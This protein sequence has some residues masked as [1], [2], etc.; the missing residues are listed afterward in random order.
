MWVL[1]TFPLYWGQSDFCLMTTHVWCLLSTSSKLHSIAPE[2]ASE[3][4]QGSSVSSQ[5]SWR[6]WDEVLSQKKVVVCYRT[7][8]RTGYQSTHTPTPVMFFFPP[9]N[10]INMTTVII[11]LWF[12]CNQS[13]K[14]PNKS[15]FYT[16]YHILLSGSLWI[17]WGDVVMLTLWWLS[18]ILQVSSPSLSH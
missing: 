12:K 18:E 15:A 11:L 10:L 3:V 16:L 4:S 5:W 1:G 13:N 2:S 9:V 14:L 7:W 17:L 8:I 6:W